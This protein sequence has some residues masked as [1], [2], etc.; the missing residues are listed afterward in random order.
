[1]ARSLRHKLSVMARCVCLCGRARVTRLR[2][3]SISL[4]Q[5]HAA[6]AQMAAAERSHFERQIAALT[7]ELQASKAMVAELQASADVQSKVRAGYGMVSS[8]SPVPVGRHA[9]ATPGQRLRSCRPLQVHSL[10]CVL[11]NGC[12]SAGLCRCTVPGAHSSPA[13]QGSQAVA[14]GLWCGCWE[15]MKLLVA[16]LFSTS[17][18]RSGGGHSNKVWLQGAQEASLGA[19]FLQ[20]TI[21]QQA[22]EQQMCRRSNS[23]IVV[24]LQ[25]AQEALLFPISNNCV[26]A[27]THIVVWL[28]E[29]QEAQAALDARI[30]E[31]QQQIAQ[32][33]ADHAA[34]MA[35][36]KQ[37]ADAEMQ[38]LQQRIEQA[39]SKISMLVMFVQKVFWR[40]P[41]SLAIRS[42]CAGAA[43][44]PGA[45]GAGA[46]E[47]QPGGCT[48]ARAA[49]GGGIARERDA[50]V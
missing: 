28:Q 45:R 49:G 13:C 15:C 41:C 43:R 34:E 25:E 23:N 27:K 12:G 7:E 10:R 38:E 22:D 32:L 36:H 31:L 33:Q 6:A 20:L 47:Q 44:A 40:V 24:W 42:L 26:R 1:M 9:F 37:A 17:N 16:L 11:A 29:A 19:S 21:M 8:A 2:R 48:A 50:W 3:I 35:A 14:P 4:A 39:C 5:I 46:G 30:G 18:K